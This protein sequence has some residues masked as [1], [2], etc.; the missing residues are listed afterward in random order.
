MD[1]DN[2][3]RVFAADDDDI[4]R[5]EENAAELLD[6]DFIKVGTLIKGM[7]N[8]I[9]LDKMYSL[10]FGTSYESKRESIK[11]KYYLGLV[12]NLPRPEEL[13]SNT[14]NDLVDEFGRETLTTSLSSLIDYFVEIEDFD[15]CIT[16]KAYLDVFGLEKLDSSK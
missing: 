6:N 2:I 5:E 1:I 14:L 11:R 10:K 12:Q 13:H 3:F 15:S 9:L 7:E 16:L 8:Y 4:F